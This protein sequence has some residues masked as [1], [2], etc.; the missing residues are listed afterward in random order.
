MDPDWPFVLASVV[1]SLLAI[2]GYLL[3]LFT[4]RGPP[5]PDSPEFLLVGGLAMVP[6]VL[7]G[8]TG[9]WLTARG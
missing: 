3:Y 4:V 1:V 6:G 8:T 7:L 5:H 9:L 2:P